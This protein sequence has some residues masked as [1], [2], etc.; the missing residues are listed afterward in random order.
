MNVRP[1]GGDGP[2]V[3]NGPPYPEFAGKPVFL[4]SSRR[5]EQICVLR[6]T[7]RLRQAE[8]CPIRGHDS[9]VPGASFGTADGF[10]Q[11]P[12]CL[13]CCAS[14]AAGCFAAR[15]PRRNP[16]LDGESTPGTVRRSRGLWRF[17]RLDR[18]LRANRPVVR[19][20]LSTRNELPASENGRPLFARYF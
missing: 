20:T 11:L 1:M 5:S 15:E 12:P 9:N 13:T 10:C 18:A 14:P 16:R 8:S 3:V 7:S 19:A 6:G 2:N 4:D 17:L